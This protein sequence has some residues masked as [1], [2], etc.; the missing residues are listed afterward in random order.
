MRRNQQITQI[1]QFLFNVV[2]K[3]FNRFNCVDAKKSTDNTDLQFSF[4]A[5]AKLFNR[6]NCVDAKKSTDC[7]DFIVSIQC[8]SQ[9]V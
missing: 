4:N 6:F 9:T 7:T 3:L 8:G 2:A 5:I 1:S